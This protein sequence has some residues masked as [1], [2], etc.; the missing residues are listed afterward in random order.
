MSSAT[1]QG[2][3]PP[4]VSTLALL[5]PLAGF[6]AVAIVVGDESVE[7]AMALVL[8]AALLWQIWKAPLGVGVLIPVF[9]GL[10]LDSPEGRLAGGAWESP[11]TTLGTVMLAHLNVATGIKALFF[12]GM[13]LMLG[14][15]FVIA[16]LRP[17]RPA[18]GEAR[19]A[20]PPIHRFAGLALLATAVTWLW[21]AASNGNV[22]ASLWQANKLYYVPLVVILFAMAFREAP[23]YR[24][25]GHVLVLAACLKSLMAWWITWVVMGG[26]VP[27]YATTHADTILFSCAITLIIAVR[28]EEPG[29]ARGS[30]Y[31]VALPL[32][33]GGMWANN[34]RL[35][36]VAVAWAVATYYVVMPWTAR[37]RALTRAVLLSVPLIVLYL[38]VGWSS[39]SVVFAPARLVASVTSHD[40]NGS[41][42]WRDLENFNL[43]YTFAQQ[44]LM[45]TGF[46]HEYIERVRLPDISAAFPMFRYLPHNGMLALWVSG[47]CVGFT[48][49]WLLL[50]AGIFFGA[51]AYHHAVRPQ[52]R[53]A[54]LTCIAAVVVYMISAYGDT[55]LGSW[56]GVFT[57]GP[58]IALASTLAGTTGAWR[59]ARS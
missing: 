53:A 50:I 28:L 1:L 21:G 4:A 45:G 23:D 8:L 10:T 48:A 59:T 35:A 2:V 33:I 40:V 52:D 44:P 9:L 36:W 42:R 29:R 26:P 18:A 16:L 32:I 54:A 56:A 14:L 37:K 49:Q 3:R 25:L 47:G 12:S 38:V 24:P 57:A 20:L 41:T 5:A 58:A 34:R 19:P 6:A 31:W 55:T 51:R 46:G 22:S 43:V 39:Q 11:L 17:A 13:D 27:F 7:V 30:L 15:L